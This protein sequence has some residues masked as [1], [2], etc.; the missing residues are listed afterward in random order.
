MWTLYKLFNS[1]CLFVLVS[2]RVKVKDYL[3]EL[4]NF[5]GTGVRVYYK[6][7]HTLVKS[8]EFIVSGLYPLIYDTRLSSKFQEN[9]YDGLA[10]SES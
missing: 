8:A 3:S 6:F 9:C 5:S 7:F 1:N 4:Q 10:L 2:T